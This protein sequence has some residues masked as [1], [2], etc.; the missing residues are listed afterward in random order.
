MA[1]GKALLAA[2]AGLTAGAVIAWQRAT[3]GP[4]DPSAGERW[5]TVTVNIDPAELRPEKLPAPLSE[6]GDRIETRITPAPGDRGTELAVRLKDP[7]APAAHSVPA[8]LAG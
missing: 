8:R 5:L 2:A 4:A 3:A 7:Q 1:K 6:Y